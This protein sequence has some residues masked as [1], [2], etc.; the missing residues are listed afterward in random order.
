MSNVDDILKQV[1]R[2]AVDIHTAEELKKK[3]ES[4]RPLRIKLGVDP[5]RPD[6]HIGHSVV[7]NKLQQFQ[8]LGHQAVLIIGD[9]TAMVGDPSGR[10][11][12][13]PEL[14]RDE[15][16]A[17]AQTYLDQVGKLLDLEKAEVVRNSE[18]LR[19]MQ[20]EDIVKIA[21]KFTVA[22]FL[23][24][25]DFA[26]RYKEGTPIA[27]HEFLYLFMQGYDS[28][29]VKSD[30]ELGGTDQTFN[31]LVGR[32]LQRHNG[33]EPQCTMTM[34]ILPGTD[35]NLKMSKSYDN[36]IGIDEDPNEM[37]GK[38]MSIPDAAMAQYFELMT[39]VPMDEVESL[40]AGHP[41]DAKMRLAREI[42]TRFHSAD[43]AEA[44]VTRWGEVFQQK[45]IPD[46]IAEFAIG[47][48]DLEDG[49]IFLP[50]LLKDV[51][52]FAS[53]GSE[54]R[55][56]ISQGGVKIN[57]EKLTDANAALTVEDGMILQVGKKKFGKLV[58][59]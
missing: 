48:G 18:W 46:D 13:R 15:V 37:F 16:E 28:V 29:A 3:L 14:T 19:P 4:G 53:S 52:G 43:A 57:G 10:S 44:A 5:T 55:R 2:G 9:F 27:I 11:K 54:A 41:R 32:D 7:I 24:R 25:Q 6:L 45:Q 23:E 51:C 20:F 33:L 1:S 40:I 58:L 34:P 8:E 31:L 35:G 49:A 50:T 59:K 42:T 36:H 39:F 17:N 38:V 22:Q 21:G 26:N 30:V 47:A 56:L 12:T